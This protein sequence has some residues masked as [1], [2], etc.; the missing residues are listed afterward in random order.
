MEENDDEN[1]A[2]DD[3]WNGRSREWYWWQLIVTVSE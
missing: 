3:T 2:E 1:D